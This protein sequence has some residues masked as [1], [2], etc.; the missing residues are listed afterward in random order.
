MT[1]QK[2]STK[3]VDG[4]EKAALRCLRKGFNSLSLVDVHYRLSLRLLF[5][6]VRL[7]FHSAVDWPVRW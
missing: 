2:A 1:A 4:V 7:L 3:D 5:L 6:E